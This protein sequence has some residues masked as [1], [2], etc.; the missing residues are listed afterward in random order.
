MSEAQ[1]KNNV[2][3]QDQQQQHQ[4]QPYPENQTNSAESEKL[5]IKMKEGWL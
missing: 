1:N 5:Y 2:A 3:S 4:Q